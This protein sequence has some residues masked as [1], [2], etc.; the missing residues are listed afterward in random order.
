MM[1]ASS[2]SQIFPDTALDDDRPSARTQFHLR[3]SHA[4]TFLDI[5]KS[6]YDVGHASPDVPLLQY[7]A[8]SSVHPQ[9]HVN[10]SSTR[11]RDPQQCRQCSH[12][13]HNRPAPNFRLKIP[14]Q[15]AYQLTLAAFVSSS[16][17]TLTAGVPIDSK[18]NDG[19]GSRR[20]SDELD[21]GHS[22]SSKL[23]VLAGAMRK[24]R[25]RTDERMN[26]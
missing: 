15:T 18:G 9:Q 2:R 14:W 24:D 17:P 4:P 19:R 6:A 22:V 3:L 13:R 25:G 10:P 16:R 21:D 12:L 11:V 8:V 1:Y 20:R 23:A 5:G 26:E 7:A